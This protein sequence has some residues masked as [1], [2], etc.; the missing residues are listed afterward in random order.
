MPC[1][2]IPLL[3]LLDL[4]G[5]V[6]ALLPLDVG[7]FGTDGMIPTLPI[8]YEGLLEHPVGE[9]VVLLEL[10]SHLEVQGVA[11]ELTLYLQKGL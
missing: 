9:E 10:E 2:L 11:V 8:E 7:L 6:L 3:L 1:L 5:D 4:L